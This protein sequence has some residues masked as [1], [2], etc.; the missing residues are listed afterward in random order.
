VFLAAILVSHCGGLP[1][2]PAASSL[3]LPAR[4]AVKSK[5]ERGYDIVDREQ[6]LPVKAA[7]VGLP[8]VPA[9][10]MLSR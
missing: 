7:D 2:A 1:S 4:F 5:S 6:D 9:H 8:L 3:S 10:A